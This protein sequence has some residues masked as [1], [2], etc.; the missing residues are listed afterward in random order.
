MHERLRVLLHRAELA[1]QYQRAARARQLGMHQVEVAALEHLVVLGGLTPG[2]LGQRLGLTSGGV[3]ALAGRLIDAGYVVRRPHPRDRRM[4]VLTATDEGRAHVAEFLEPVVAPV[5]RA[6][7]WL[8]G[9]GAE[10][11]RFL[12]ALVLLKERGAAATPGPPVEGSGDDYT[13]ALLM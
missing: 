6:L 3:T 13:P 2:E 11:E 8:P 10:L 9:S 1:G 12:D 4:R 5:D 7:G